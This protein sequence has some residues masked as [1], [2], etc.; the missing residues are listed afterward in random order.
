MTKHNGH[1]ATVNE[2]Y[3]WIAMP[4]GEDERLLAFN[5]D[6]LVLPL[7]GRD[8]GH[9]SDE[10]GPLAEFAATRLGVRYEIRR[11]KL[12]RPMNPPQ[13]KKGR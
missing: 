8:R 9:V 4:V 6:G 7:V 3:A 13:R 11:F 10:L 12:D 1:G 2:L 5:V